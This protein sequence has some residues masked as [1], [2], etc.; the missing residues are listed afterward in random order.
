MLDFMRRSANS[1]VVKALLVLLI[2]SFAAWGIGDIFRAQSGTDVVASV[3]ETDIPTQRFQSEFAQEVDRLRQQFGPQMTREQARAMGLD[4]MVLERLV[5]MQL[6]QNGAEDLGL[7]VSD[8]VIADDIKSTEAFFNANGQFDRAVYTAVLNRNNLTEDR[9]IASLRTGLVRE[10]YLTPIANGAKAPA[11]MVDVL[12]KRLA[13]T[14]V[15]DAVRIPHAQVGGVSEP[16]DA[17]LAAYHEE[18]SNRF[19][20]PEYRQITALVLRS[21]DVQNTIQ[22]SDED[23]QDAYDA[24]AAEFSTPEIRTLKQILV[25][26]EADAKRA[27]DLLDQGQSVADAAQAVG[28]NA[29][30]TNLGAFTRADAAAL[31]PAIAEAAFTAPAGGHSQPVQ[32]PLGW[33]VLVVEDVK[34]GTTQTLDDVRDTLVQDLRA[35]RAL[36]A[37]F[38]L[39]NDL[40]DMLAGGAQLEEA[41]R[42]LNL[43]IT[44]LNA[45]DAQGNTPAGTPADAPY[46]A[47]IVAKAVEVDEGRD[48]L[49]TE[50]EDGQG[51]FVLRVDAVTPPAVK[52]LA[53]VREHVQA[54]MMQD[55]RA[56]KAA[57]LAT[58]AEQRLAGGQDPAAVAEAV[59]GVAFTTEAFN[60]LGD[61]LEQGALPATLVNKA[62]GLNTGDVTQAQ[63]TDAHTVARLKTV[64]AATLDRSGQLYQRL[65]TQTRNQMQGDLLQQLSAALQ[66][67]HPVKV[68]QA[69]LAGA[70]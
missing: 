17:E 67:Q 52:P 10:Q 36:D 53:D 6:F 64:N 18:H 25:K 16:T 37:L 19:M 65:A 32:S 15:L 9:Y 7:M 11:P 35:E 69:A 51:F 8:A 13:E 34:A 56:E 22:I 24:R 58:Q 39:S 21:E 61:G 23:L 46:V 41:A 5:N 43:D 29:G 14:R 45:V 66:T 4:A 3:G 50:T 26:D 47:D 55:R 57:E 68:N 54:L 30:M 28:A 2:I 33:H 31:S 27:A 70:N 20:A 40:D 38:E 60:R 59:G 1:I 44:R 62:F 49:M 63:G 12:Y 42:Q 48:S